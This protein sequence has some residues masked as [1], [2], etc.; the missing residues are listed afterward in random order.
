MSNTRGLGLLALAY[1]AFAATDT[2]AKLLTETMHPVQIVWARQLGLVGAVLVVLCARGPRILRSG[3]PILQTA[4]GIFAVAA[5]VCM[6]SAF[7]FVPLADATAVTFV[8]PLFVSVLGVLFLGERLTRHRWIVMGLGLLGALVVIRPGLGVFHPAIALVLVAAVFLAL[9]QVMSRPLSAKDSTAT[10]LAYTALTGLLLI[11]VP[12]PLVWQM[13]AS[14][15]VVALVVAMAVMAA[16]GEILTIR[17]FEIAEA[18]ALA[19]MHYT[20][21]IWATGFGWVVFGQLPDG[22][23]W[24]GT[25]IIAGTGVYILVSNRVASRVL[26]PL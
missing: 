18:V 9:R 7:A 11:S 22:W 13:P 20:L 10:T 14:G 19:P 23:T 4:R 5:P 26:A 2:M 17:A 25:A 16:I 3:A 21:M 1:I 24:L 12:L 15:T 6:A 8:S